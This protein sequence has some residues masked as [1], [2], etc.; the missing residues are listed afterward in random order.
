VGWS[1]LWYQ[2]FVLDRNG[3]DSGAGNVVGSTPGMFKGS[4]NFKNMRTLHLWHIK[5]IGGK[6][7]FILRAKFETDGCVWV[8]PGLD[9]LAWTNGLNEKKHLNAEYGLLAA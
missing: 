8:Y 3:V 1:S 2:R 5:N 6:C 9:P 7:P 4:S